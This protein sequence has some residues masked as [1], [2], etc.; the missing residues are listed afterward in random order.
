MKFRLTNDVLY[1]TAV[2]IL[3]GLLARSMYVGYRN[4]PVF[5]PTNLKRVEEYYPR[6]EFTED[7]I[8]GTDGIFLPNG[9]IRGTKFTDIVSIQAMEPIYG[10]YLFLLVEH[11]RSDATTYVI[12]TDYVG[13]DPDSKHKINWI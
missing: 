12:R 2:T 13:I 3:S 11:N 1:K 9:Q 8:F 4:S 7:G 5:H 6:L 10:G